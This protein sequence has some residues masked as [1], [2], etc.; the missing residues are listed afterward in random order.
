MT[1]AADHFAGLPL[2][3]VDVTFLS[4]DEGGRQV[5][6]SFND[7]HWYR[8]HL[9]IQDPGLGTAVGGDRCL[10]V[11]FVDGPEKPRPS[12]F[13]RYRL[14]LLYYPTVDYSGLTPGTT[15]TIREGSRIVGSGTVIT[16]DHS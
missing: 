12:Q 13:E 14:R 8:P 4:A 15:F 3:E 5:L 7:Q 11:A 10:G 2:L 6:P 16:R 9:V 1:R